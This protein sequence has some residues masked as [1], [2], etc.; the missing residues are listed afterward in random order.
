VLKYADFSCLVG[1]TLKE[2]NISRGGEGE[3]SITFTTTDGEEYKLFHYQDCCEGVWIEDV[4]G[5]VGDLVGSPIVLAEV[6]KGDL[7][8]LES[9]HESFTWTFYRIATQMGHVDIRW[10]GES[11]GYYSEE[12]DFALI[13]RG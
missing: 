7:G 9:F 12:V 10:Y 4:I 6:S 5:D 8:P 13:E 2:V 3:D 11:N 1:K